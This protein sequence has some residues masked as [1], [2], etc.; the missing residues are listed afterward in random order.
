MATATALT[1]VR[2]RN[3]ETEPTPNGGEGYAI[4]N[5]EGEVI[6]YSPSLFGMEQRVAVA[7][8]MGVDQGK[9]AYKGDNEDDNGTFEVW[10]LVGV[11]SPVADPVA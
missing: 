6:G 7:K 10:G 4:E 2:V 5:Q 1:H 8:A 9:I 11:P 3:E